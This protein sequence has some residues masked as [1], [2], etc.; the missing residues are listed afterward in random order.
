MDIRGALSKL[1]PNN[2]ELWT[3]DGLPRVEALQALGLK[4]VTRGQIT[5]A[6][7]NFTRFNLGV[8]DEKEDEPE[9]R[10]NTVEEPEEDFDLQASSPFPEPP[11]PD[12]VSFMGESQEF[13]G[14]AP[15]EPPPA[16][17]PSIDP[18]EAA[19]ALKAADEA[20]AKARVAAEAAKRAEAEA[21]RLRDAAVLAADRSRTSNENQAVIM[22][23][24]E[25][26]KPKLKPGEAPA[27]TAPAP[28]DRAHVRPIGYGKEMPNYPVKQ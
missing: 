21:N 13:A 12:H 16:P 4:G 28:I 15:Q 17:P 7:P 5:A 11:A 3:G 2:D 25:S 23:F 9:G 8:L 1:D 27:P 18:G 14:A 22:N 26:T 19:A 24:L 20:L 6:S 10:S